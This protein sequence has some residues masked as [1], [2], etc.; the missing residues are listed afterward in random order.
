MIFALGEEMG[1]RMVRTALS[2]AEVDEVW[3]RWRSGQAVK[4]LAREMRRN[5]STVRDLLKRTGGVRPVP[6]RRWE[7]RLS[8]GER[9]E[10]SR[11][12]AAGDSLRRIAVGLS[13]AP[14]TV[15][16]EGRPQRW[17]QRLTGAGRGSRGVGAGRPAEADEVGPLARTAQ[18]GRGQ[19]RA[20]SPSQNRVV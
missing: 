19:A 12:L 7:L 13:R 17:L 6:R 14:S 1:W 16:R 3:R 9:E 15:S 20:A 10:I 8:L 4:V 5:P 18:H 11:G 2:P